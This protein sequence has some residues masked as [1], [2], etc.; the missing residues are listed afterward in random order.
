MILLLFQAARIIDDKSFASEI[1]KS[2]L[3]SF[4]EQVETL[5]STTKNKKVGGLKYIDRLLEFV[6]IV[7]HPFNH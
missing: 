1:S 4:M 5:I 6:S 2:C 7:E 3:L